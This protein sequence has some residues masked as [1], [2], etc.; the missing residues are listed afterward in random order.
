MRHMLGLVDSTGYAIVTFY[1]KG[2]SN[3]PQALKDFEHKEGTDQWVKI[4]GFIRVFNGQKSV[5]GINLL[6]IQKMDEVTNHLL[7]VF[8]SHNVRKKGVL[9]N[10]DLDAQPANSRAAM[11]PSGGN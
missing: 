4:Y 11:A 9:N 8:V 3:I 6:E 1:Q 5:V 10:K 7:Q 2:E